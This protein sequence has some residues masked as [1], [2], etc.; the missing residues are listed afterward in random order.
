MTIRYRALIEAVAAKKRRDPE[1]EFK[2]KTSKMPKSNAP[3]EQDFID[4]HGNVKVDNHPW[5]D[6][7]VFDG[8]STKQT[9]HQPMNGER[10]SDRQ[11]SSPTL[12]FADFNGKASTK[13]TTPRR[14]DN[15]S[16]GDSDSTPVRLSPTAVNP[17]KEI[18]EETVYKNLHRVIE[19]NKAI[20]AHFHNG[21]TALITP[22]T[23]KRLLAIES[24]L[25]KPNAANFRRKLD[26]SPAALM[27]LLNIRSR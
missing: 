7:S 16:N 27:S 23:A 4:K 8:T 13:K 17:A 2:P 1:E 26:S 3:A 14:G 22:D 6:D 5:M 25:S 10:K 12:G 11:G 9:K 20:T 18:K 24:Q 21:D 19:S 15:L